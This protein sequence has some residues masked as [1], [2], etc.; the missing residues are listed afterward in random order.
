VRLYLASP[1]ILHHTDEDDDRSAITF[2]IPNAKSYTKMDL[3]EVF[4]L[5]SILAST[6]PDPE[7]NDGPPPGKP[8]HSDLQSGRDPHVE[9]FGDPLRRILGP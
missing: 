7:P 4:R 6:A 3:A 1:D 5:M 9:S 8:L 2:W